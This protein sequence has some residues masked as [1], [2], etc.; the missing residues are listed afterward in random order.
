MTGGKRGAVT[1]VHYPL[2]GLDTTRQLGGLRRPRR[3]QVRRFRAGRVERAHVRVVGGVGVQPG[4]QLLD[5]VLFGAGQHRVG[6]LLTAD[7]RRLGRR[8]RGR[9]E[10]AEAVGRVNPRFVGQL[11]GQ[12]L[13]RGILGVHQLTGVGGTE[14]IRTPGRAKQ[15]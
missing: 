15:Q 12:P 1:Q 9:A 13:R 2:A 8:L 3:G 11:G 6:A 4:Q 5:V 10:T 14:Q 7:G